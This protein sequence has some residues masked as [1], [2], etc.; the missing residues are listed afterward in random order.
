M[1]NITPINKIADIQQVA[2]DLRR[3]LLLEENSDIK[4]DFPS[5]VKRYTAS[6]DSAVEALN[7]GRKSF[8]EGQQEQFIV[9]SG[10][11]AVGMSIVTNSI[12]TPEGID[13]SWPNLSGFIANPYRKRGLGRLSLQ[14]RLQSVRYNFDG[15]AWTL[16]RIGNEASERLVSNQG[17]IRTSTTL[18]DR[19]L[20]LWHK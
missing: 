10:G 16:V 3:L 2:L 19:A 13:P 11:A 5:I 12:E 6:F 1:D 8:L 14:R 20:Y 7:N 15:H 17:F 18:G 4:N 9:F